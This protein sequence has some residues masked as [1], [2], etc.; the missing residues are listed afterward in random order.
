MDEAE[1]LAC[2]KLNLMLGFL[3]SKAGSRKLRLFACACCR[4]LWP[5]LKGNRRAVLAA[6]QF[7]DRAGFRQG[8][9]RT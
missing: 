8:T 9:W 6:E 4:R 2:K 1:W 3:K 5:R 7:V